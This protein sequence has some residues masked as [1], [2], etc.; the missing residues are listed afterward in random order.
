MPLTLIA[1]AVVATAT[2]SPIVPYLQ[3]ATPHGISI[4]WKGDHASVGRVVIADDA[5]KTVADVSE[6]TREAH[7]FEIEGLRP[8]THYQYQA[9]DDAVR[10]GQGTFHTNPGPETKDYRFIV[11]GDTG[12]GGKD[13]FEIARRLWEWH[14]DFVIHVGDIIYYRG[15]A[16]L[17]ASRFIAPYRE[18]I[19]K[20]VMYP[21]LGNHDVKTAN[22]QP[23]LNF[24]DPPHT[25]GAESPRYYRFSYGDMDIFGLDTMEPCGPGTPEYGWLEQQLAASKAPWKLAFFHYPVFSAVPDPRIK[26]MRAAWGPLFAKYHVDLVFQ[27]HVHAYERIKPQGDVHYWVSGGGGAKLVPVPPAPYLAVGQEVYHFLGVTKK[28]ETV[29]V[30]AIDESG[31]VFDRDTVTR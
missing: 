24:F 16:E 6:P 27:G 7:R 4:L 21:C 1:A 31:K 25:P 2:P 19:Q 23:Y 20:V 29:T 3:G 18:L 8:G 14:P 26:G 28:G 5:G 17:Y 10:I 12:W 13:Q 22:G 11:V 30:E 9:F 15:E